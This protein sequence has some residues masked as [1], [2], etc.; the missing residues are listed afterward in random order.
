MKNIL[1][2]IAIFCFSSSPILAQNKLKVEVKEAAKPDVY[3]DGKKYDHY[4]VDL[5][6]ANKIESVEVLKGEQALK[7]YNAPHGV[8]LIK[9]K[10]AAPQL[11]TFGKNEMELTIP[12]PKP[13]TRISIRD[14]SGATMAD[15]DQ[16]PVIIIDGK[17]SDNETLDK[18]SP[19]DIES[20]N[21][22]KGE[23]ALEEY[24]ASNGVIIVKT[25]NS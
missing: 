21:V 19:D 9:T 10:N 1:I 25:K 7:K 11:P 12:S 16:N 24:K 8:I 3:I 17:V 23:K 20:I 4:I 6:D 2:V 18:L 14:K 22:L 13:G 15:G 5:L